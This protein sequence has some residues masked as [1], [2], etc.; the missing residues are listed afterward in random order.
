M[1][2]A[3]CNR[4]PLGAVEAKRLAIKAGCT[5]ESTENQNLPKTFK[6][7]SF[8][9]MDKSKL[10]L[11]DQES[12]RNQPGRAKRKGISNHVASTRHLARAVIVQHNPNA[13]IATGR[14]AYVTTNGVKSHSRTAQS[15]ADPNGF[16]SYKRIC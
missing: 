6:M 8:G 4:H 3:L 5:A 16:L 14:K 10:P 7:G 1:P 12:R 2:V 9:K 11:T 15:R 13:R